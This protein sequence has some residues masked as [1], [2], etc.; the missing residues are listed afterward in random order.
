MQR[1]GPPGQD[2]NNPGL[3]YCIEVAALSK[4]DTERTINALTYQ[5]LYHI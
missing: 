5:L 1:I 4:N 2:M 3:Y